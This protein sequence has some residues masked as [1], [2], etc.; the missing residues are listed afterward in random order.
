MRAD[1]SAQVLQ[2]LP[3]WVSDFL[4]QPRYC[5]VMSI[6]KNG[7]VFG[8]PL[9]FKWDGTYFYL[10]IRAGRGGV[11]RLRRDPGMSLTVCDECVPA[12]WVV[13]DG[14]AEEIP[15]EG[16]AISLSIMRQ[17]KAQVSDVDI[18]RFASNWLS[19]GR[20]VFRVA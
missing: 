5:S 20:V 18:D 16:N 2:P 4:T 13:V 19:T 3:S 9:G 15:D 6:R 10:T 17:A 12:T 11:H 8:V 7:R 1:S 14:I